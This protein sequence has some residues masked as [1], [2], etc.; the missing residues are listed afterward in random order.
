VDYCT[1][2]DLYANGLPRGS[3]PNPGRVV[4]AANATA[5]TIPLGEHGFSAEDPLTI[6]SDAGGTMPAPLVSGTTYYAIP[7]TDDAFQVAATAGGAAI[8]I[9]SAGSR[10]VVGAPINY[11]AAI[12]FASRLIDEMLVGHV[13]LVEG[14]EV[15]EIIKITAAEIA[16]G[17]LALGSGSV[18]KSLGQIVD[19]A[20]KRLERWA[21]GT[22]L[23]AANRPASANTAAA[24]VTLTA[25]SRDNRGWRRFGGL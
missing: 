18:S 24:G 19:E 11:A 7:V 15:P 2:A 22:P 25:T 16:I 3:I 6:R 10:F 12:R 14:D 9:T 23:R 17:K 5:N 21:K 20:R 1:T 4:T 8:D 13:V